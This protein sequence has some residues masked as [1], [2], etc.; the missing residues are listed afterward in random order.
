VNNT[1]LGRMA[2]GP[3]ISIIR[4]AV[5]DLKGGQIKIIVTWFFHL[6]ASSLILLAVY[7]WSNIPVWAYLMCCYAGYSVLTVR[8]FLEHQANESVRARTVIVED[9]GPL[10]FLFLNN[11]LHLVHHAYPTVAWYELPKMF[12]KNRDRFIM[13]NKGYNFKSYVEI[14]KRYSFSKKEPVAYPFVTKGQNALKSSPTKLGQ[15]A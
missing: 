15:E 9:K 11:N 13:M 2:I 7:M 8:T 14:F 10:S 4:F 1:L 5:A 3:A 6:F 12:E